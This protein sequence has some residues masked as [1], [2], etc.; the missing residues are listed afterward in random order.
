MTR[1][2]ERRKTLAALC[3]HSNISMAM[4]YLDALMCGRRESERS[5]EINAF[6]EKMKVFISHIS[7]R[8][9]LTNTGECPIG[10][11]QIDPVDC[12]PCRMHFISVQVRK[13]GEHSVAQSSAPGLLRE[14]HDLDR[15]DAMSA[16]LRA[17]SQQ[18]QC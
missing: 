15:I 4:R 13:R 5:E 11:S 14:W 1:I 12:S 16:H 9:L 6:D 3:L 10:N 17:L 8:V 2:D 18:L 7:D